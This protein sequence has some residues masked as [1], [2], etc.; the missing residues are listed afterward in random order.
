MI[1]Y[2]AHNYIWAEFLRNYNGSDP[3]SP[4]PHHNE[5]ENSKSGKMNL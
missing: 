5:T 2:S 3:S 1:F 4:S